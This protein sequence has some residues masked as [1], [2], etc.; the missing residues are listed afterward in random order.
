MTYRTKKVDEIYL[1]Y[2]SMKN[3]MTEEAQFMRLLPLER[4]DFIIKDIPVDLP[5]EHI[6]MKPSPESRHGTDRTGIISSVIFTVPL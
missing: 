1:I 3:A 5:M 4:P 2:T 6:A